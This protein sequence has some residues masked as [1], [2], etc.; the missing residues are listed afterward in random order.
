MLLMVNVT[1]ELIKEGRELGKAL[2]EA[3]KA[4]VRSL[5]RTTLAMVVGMFPIATAGGTGAELRNG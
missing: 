1:N 4:R 2:I 3:G 5:L